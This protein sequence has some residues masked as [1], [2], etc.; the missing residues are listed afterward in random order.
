MSGTPSSSGGD[1]DSL[2]PLPRSASRWSVYV[3]VPHRSASPTP[4]A[5][6]VVLAGLVLSASALAAPVTGLI[7]RSDAEREAGIVLRATGIEGEEALP[8]LALD[9][10]DVH[11]CPARG[12]C[13]LGPYPKSEF[14]AFGIAPLYKGSVTMSVRVA[15]LTKPVFT[16]EVPGSCPWVVASGAIT[17]GPFRLVG[18]AGRDSLGQYAVWVVYDG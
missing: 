14:V 18:D 3:A 16:C 7:G 5:A 9:M 11:I 8:F 15:G 17:A 12:R 2:L 1:A 10:N 6:A 13:E 4:P